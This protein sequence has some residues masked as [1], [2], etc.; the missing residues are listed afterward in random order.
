MKHA[1]ENISYKYSVASDKR[2]F[3]FG[4]ASIH[5]IVKKNEKDI[6]CVER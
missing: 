5:P 4:Y 3:V 1:S 6:Y 2:I